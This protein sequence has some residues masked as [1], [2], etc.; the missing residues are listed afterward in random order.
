M[1]EKN[2]YHK[3]KI[4][5]MCHRQMITHENKCNEEKITI[6][7]NITKFNQMPLLVRSADLEA[8][9]QIGL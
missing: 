6:S 9:S 3:E 1:N 8:S 4:G 5:L 7:S 2:Y